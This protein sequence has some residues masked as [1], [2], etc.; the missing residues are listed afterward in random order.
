MMQ[1]DLLALTG[2]ASVTK[3]NNGFLGLDISERVLFSRAQVAV[4]AAAV[5]VVAA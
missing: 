4:L 1:G 5:V 2:E 3:T